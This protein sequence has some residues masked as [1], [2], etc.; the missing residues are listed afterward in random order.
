MHDLDVA[1]V[2]IRKVLKLVDE[3]DLDADEL[4]A[5]RAE[6]DVRGE[7]EV[8]LDA[9]AD[10]DERKLALK[11]KNRIDAAACG[12]TPMISMTEAS[13]VLRERRKAR[14]RQSAG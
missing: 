1:Q 12:A 13:R 10:A 5:L 7:C 11:I 4:R 9:C 14:G 2:R 8:D 6:L 3:L